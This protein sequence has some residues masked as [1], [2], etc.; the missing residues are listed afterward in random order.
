MQLCKI[1]TGDSR[2]VTIQLEDS[3]GCLVDHNRKKAF[4]AD[5]DNQ[6][7]S[8]KDGLWYQILGD[9]STIPICLLEP[10]KPEDLE[11]RMK[12][13]YRAC[14]ENAKF[15][16]YIEAAQSAI[17]DKLL[18]LVGMGI[19]GMIVYFLVRHFWG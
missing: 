15:Q 18:W 3:M 19:S 6:F 2:R 1:Y 13:V 11:E 9:R 14:K 17:F 5:V 12:E 10:A 8:T 16:Q 7:L 4:L